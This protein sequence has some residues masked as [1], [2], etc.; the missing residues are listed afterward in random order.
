KDRGSLSRR[1][2]DTTTNFINS[3]TKA[4]LE[5]LYHNAVDSKLGDDDVTTSSLQELHK[6]QKQIQKYSINNNA[7]SPI[8]RRGS[9]VPSPTNSTGL[10]IIREE[11]QQ[12]PFLSSM[13]Q[14]KS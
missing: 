12:N 4:H 11:H 10:H 9:V 5:G 2:S 3:S 8:I 6:L 14:N 1:A 7:D 13:L